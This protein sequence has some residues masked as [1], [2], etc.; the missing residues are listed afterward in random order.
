M[1][2]VTPGATGNSHERLNAMKQNNR[3]DGAD[4]DV[5]MSWAVLEPS[6]SIRNHGENH[7]KPG[8][9]NENNHSPP[10]PEAS[11]KVESADDDNAWEEWAA[12]NPSHAL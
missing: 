3:A 1:L 8:T 7:A 4:I 2:W 12:Q 6:D 11:P 10:V 5:I 9:F